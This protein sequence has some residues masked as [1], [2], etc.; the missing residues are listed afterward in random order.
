[1]RMLNT[2]AQHRAQHCAQRR[3]QSGATLVAILI[4]IVVGLIVITGGI[5]FYVNNVSANR[6]VLAASRLDLELTSAM[7]AMA[8]E[9]RRAQYIAGAE[10]VR[11]RVPCADV[12]CDS[13]DDFSLQTGD[14]TNGFARID[15]S[16]DRRDQG[17]GNAA[18][19]NDDECT[20]FRLNASAVE[21]KTRCSGGGGWLPLTDP[22]TT[23]VTALNFGVDCSESAGFYN[24]TVRVSLAGHLAGEPT[25]TRTLVHELQVRAP[26]AATSQ[27]DY[28]RMPTP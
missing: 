9:I 4:G 15:F 2:R 14:A 5:V 19:Q 26:L 28:C 10:A 21:M 18:V 23:V 25:R 24:R 3:T 13:A 12:F 7:D 27:P 22:A 6:F 16:Y 20:G 1:M 17:V 8:R 11:Y